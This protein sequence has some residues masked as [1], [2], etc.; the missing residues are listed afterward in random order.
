MAQAAIAFPGFKSLLSR[1]LKAD[2]VETRE[3]PETWS[4]HPAQTVNMTVIANRGANGTISDAA[5]SSSTSKKGT[6]STWT[7]PFEFKVERLRESLARNDSLDDDAVPHF[8][9]SSINAKAFAFA[10]FQ[11]DTPLP[12]VAVDE[13]GYLELIW[14]LNGWT[15]EVSFVAQQVHAWARNRRSTDIWSGPIDEIP[16]ELAELIKS[17]SKSLAED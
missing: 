4:A 6:A 2:P 13:E 1:S 17:F 15:L 11:P 8:D 3:G 16:H 14:R 10:F 12:T 7:L 9:T 5:V